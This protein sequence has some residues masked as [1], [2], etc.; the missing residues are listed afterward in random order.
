[1]VRSY[2]GAVLPGSGGPGSG[3]VSGDG[4]GV[5]ISGAGPG[6]G[7]PALFLPGAG[8][9]RGFSGLYAC[10]IIRAIMC[11]NY[12]LSKKVVFFP[13]IYSKSAQNARTIYNK[14]IFCGAPRGLKIQIKGIQYIVYKKRVEPLYIVASARI[15][16]YCNIW[17]IMKPHNT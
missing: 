8:C 9:L 10:C 2:S 16:E 12:T 17:S 7:A 4:P 14:G 15:S 13:K 6:S 3:M 11:H 5:L 1:M